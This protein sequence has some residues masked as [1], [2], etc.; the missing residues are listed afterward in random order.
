MSKD[1]IDA[2]HLPLKRM[3]VAK[4]F[5]SD[6]SIPYVTDHVQRLHRILP[7]HLSD[8]R[9]HRRIGIVKRSHTAAVE[10]RQA[11][12]VRMLVRIAPPSTEAEKGE[13]EVG[14]VRAVHAEQLTHVQSGAPDVRRTA[15]AGEGG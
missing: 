10:E 8:V 7:N 11:P 6:R 3:N 1:P 2:P 5:I 13:V 14:G 9:V 12:A 4:L 15:D